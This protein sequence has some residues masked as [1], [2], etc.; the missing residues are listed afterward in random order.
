MLEQCAAMGVDG[1]YSFLTS[2]YRR[3]RRRRRLAPTCAAILLLGCKVCTAE[4]PLVNGG[5][6]Q[7]AETDSAVIEATAILIPSVESQEDDNHRRCTPSGDCFVWTSSSPTE[8]EMDMV[9]DA[10]GLDESPTD[11]VFLEG[12]E[13]SNCG[14]DEC[15]AIVEGQNSN[16]ATC[17]T[18]DGNGEVFQ[19]SLPSESG[20]DQGI[21]KY[22]SSERL[23]NGA[24][25]SVREV[26]VTSVETCLSTGT[27]EGGCGS[28]PDAVPGTTLVDQI[29]SG[30]GDSEVDKASFAELG[31]QQRAVGVARAWGGD[32]DSSVAHEELDPEAT[33]PQTPTE[34]LDVA[35][36]IVKTSDDSRLENYAST[37]QESRAF[38]SDGLRATS[39]APVVVDNSRESGTAQ[40]ERVDSDESSPE[41]STAAPSAEIDFH[42]SPEA[43]LSAS[44]VDSAE[45]GVQRPDGRQL[46]QGEGWLMDTERSIP[47]VDGQGS[48][49]ASVSGGLGTVDEWGD[50]SPEAYLATHVQ[51]METELLKKLREEPDVRSLLDM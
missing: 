42:T 12:T 11:V 32:E 47:S 40:G 18:S 27:G 33:S 10:T 24:A 20:E 43:R 25:Q 5:E 34:S 4:E 41:V 28:E 22:K 44:A 48:G 9:A 37:V 8:Q 2:R 14:L 17:R 23:D 45:S 39:T 31:T 50:V 16:T 15:A 38:A 7:S 30:A 35:P 46:D 3:R 19:E 13:E 21:D 1:G 49:T 26:P 6:V 36:D 51:W 29:S